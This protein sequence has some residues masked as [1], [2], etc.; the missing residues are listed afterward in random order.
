[1]FAIPQKAKDLIKIEY[2]VNEPSRSS[3][4]ASM[5][6]HADVATISYELAD[7]KLS[8]PVKEAL[9]TA[10]YTQNR[11][12]LDWAFL[13]DML[14]DVTLLSSTSDTPA[15]D[16]TRRYVIRH[17]DSH[18]SFSQSTR[19][20]LRRNSYTKTFPI[21][22]KHVMLLETATEIHY[23][24]AP[25]LLHQWAWLRAFER[26]LDGTATQVRINGTLGIRVGGAV[27]DCKCFFT[28]LTSEVSNVH[29][30][31]VCEDLNDSTIR[32]LDVS[33]LRAV[34][35]AYDYASIKRYELVVE[36][37]AGK[38]KPSSR[39]R[40]V[41]SLQ[42]RKFHSNALNSSPDPVSAVG[43]SDRSNSIAHREEVGFYYVEDGDNNGEKIGDDGAVAG[44]SSP[45]ASM[46]EDNT[47]TGKKKKWYP[48]KMLFRGGKAAA[49]AVINTVGHTVSTTA[50]VVSTVAVGAGAGVVHVAEGAV[51]I[52]RGVGSTGVK[53]VKG[54]VKGVVATAETTIDLATGKESAGRVVNVV[55][56]SAKD[57]VTSVANK[58][59]DIAQGKLKQEVKSR[60]VVRSPFARDMK[61]YPVV[62]TT[63]FWNE[64]YTVNMSEEE[65]MDCL[66]NESLG[67]SMYLVQGEDDDMTT[68]SSFV[69]IRSLL[70]T[71]EQRQSMLRNVLPASAILPSVLPNGRCGETML[72]QK[73]IPL[74]APYVPSLLQVPTAQYCQSLEFTV[75]GASHL[76]YPTERP[77]S[78]SSVSG[79]TCGGRSPS[80]RGSDENGR[81]SLQ[82]QFFP[83]CI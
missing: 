49:G 77:E 71:P 68:S 59:L 24:V 3:V 66:E 74:G 46:I 17:K 44:E 53:V 26:A 37:V 36:V 76:S 28:S 70:V 41:P 4:A 51:G 79:D 62:G 81:R 38:L 25:N 20:D 50:N 63:P 69:P 22:D 34:S 82:V 65:L 56:R 13:K 73:E 57:G 8:M 80:P 52:V 43:P 61:T 16:A 75:I 32:R 83:Y 10:P 19:I 5:R 12:R 47:H 11:A 48:G 33:T 64:T 58:S 6:S 2:I 40:L 78:H 39:V 31:I 72:I 23:V 14:C 42:H 1:M 45:T 67:L 35:L 9:M 18:K 21:Q 7:Y 55:A 30:E 15:R 27:K 29:R 60:L 54:T